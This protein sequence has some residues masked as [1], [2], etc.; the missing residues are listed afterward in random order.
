MYIYDGLGC[1][2]DSGSVMNGNNVCIKNGYFYYDVP[3]NLCYIQA[4]GYCYVYIEDVGKIEI[5]YS[6]M[7]YAMRMLSKDNLDPALEELLWSLI[8]VGAL[9]DWETPK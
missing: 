8:D 5:T 9:I 2:Y 3:I 7:T 4:T 1:G 6:P